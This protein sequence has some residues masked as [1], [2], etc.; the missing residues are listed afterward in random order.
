VLL[1]WTLNELPSTQ[2]KAGLAG[3]ALC[4]EYL[5]RSNLLKGTCQVETLDERGLDLRV[6][7]EGMQSLFDSVY[8]ASSEEQEREKK[9][10]KKNRDG[11]K[12]EVDPK[13][14]R[15][16]T[17]VDKK[18]VA[19]TKTMFVYDQTVPRGGLVDEWD[20]S[21]TKVWLKLWRDLVWTTLRGVPATR[22]PYDA[23]AEARTTTDG[24][25]AWDDLVSSPAEGVDLPSTYYLGAQ[26]TSAENVSFRDI[27]RYRFL[28]HFWPFVTPIYVPA[29]VG[30]DGE[31]EFSGYAIVVPEVSDLQ[32]FAQRWEQVA[33]G[34][35]GELSGY[36]PRDAVIDLAAEAGL[37]VARRAFDVLEAGHVGSHPWMRAVDVFH[38]EKEGNNVRLRGVARVDLRRNRANDYGRARQSYWSPQ[39]RRQRIINILDERPWWSGFGRL[40]SITPQ[41]NTIQDN[42]FRHD[43]R[44]A[45]TEV[46]MTDA[47]DDGP[48]TLEQ[49]IYQ[50]ARVYV[51]GR[52][53]S[54]YE[55]SWNDV[56]GKGDA[57]EKEYNDKKL[58]I[59]REAFLAV[60]SRTGSDFVSYFTGTLCSVHRR[61]DESSFLMIARALQDEGEIERIRSLTLLALSAA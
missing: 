15:E 18:G 54:K 13:A 41:E 19:K 52:L 31:R 11:S 27:A 5:R 1:H 2:H 28:L 9:F 34:R 14:V 56:K 40:C 32:A 8:A 46:E 24:A 25:E 7:R 59:A 30:R 38:V 22:E 48:R 12:V 60:R 58:K 61:L 4:V 26:A 53:D 49:L 37:D 6:D 45:F 35:G 44:S 3:L 42:K 55:L 20:D 47:T 33:R 23:R 29:V 39:F 16:K 36:R 51:Y 10:Q 50:T 17:V 21:P 43:C 57:K